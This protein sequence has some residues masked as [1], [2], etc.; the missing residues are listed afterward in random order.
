MAKHA[1]LGQ[2][3][4][5]QMRKIFNVQAIDEANERGSVSTRSSQQQHIQGTYVL[6]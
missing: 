1:R 2:Q 4:I 6:L 3:A 5:K